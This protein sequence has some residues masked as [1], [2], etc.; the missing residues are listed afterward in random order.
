MPIFGNLPGFKQQMGKPT[1]FLTQAN[2]ENLKSVIFYYWSL[3]CNTIV[4]FRADSLGVIRNEWLAFYSAFFVCFTYPPKCSTD[5]AIW[6]LHSWCQ[7]KLLPSRRTF[8]VHQVTMHQF[9]VSLYSK[10][11]KTPQQQQWRWRRWL[12]FPLQRR[13]MW[14]Q[15]SITSHNASVTVRRGAWERIIRHRLVRL[16]R[17][18]P[19]G[20]HT[21]DQMMAT[22]CLCRVTQ[23]MSWQAA[24]ASIRWAFFFICC[25]MSTETIGLIRTGE[26]RTATST[27]TPLLT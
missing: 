7:V 12:H 20:H 9:T 10:P 2:D 6:L 23:V 21:R 26:P 15:K 22:P 4:C 17:V 19:S 8:C 16:W 25:S 14:W 13:S 11:H 24:G 3:F 18:P 27:F 1:V 5:S